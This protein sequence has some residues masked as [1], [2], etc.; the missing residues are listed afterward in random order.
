MKALQEGLKH[1]NIYFWDGSG[2]NP[3]F[4]FLALAKSII[5]TEDSVS[6][7]S[8]ALS[9]GKPTYLAALEGDSPK[10]KRFYDN[11]TRHNKVKYLTA[12][13]TLPSYS[14]APLQDAQ[15]IAKAIKDRFEYF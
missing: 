7:I 8:D 11:L 9:T 1:D 13:T 3:Y 10:F 15:K 2:D 6:M 4:T 14:Y 5:V 12:D